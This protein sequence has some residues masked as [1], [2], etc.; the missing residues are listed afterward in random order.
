MAN[1]CSRCFYDP[2][3]TLCVYVNKR[4]VTP[5]IKPLKFKPSTDPIL[6]G[7]EWMNYFD[8]LSKEEKDAYFNKD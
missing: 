4:K 5:K 6:P 7:N 2:P 8:N 3:C 1:K